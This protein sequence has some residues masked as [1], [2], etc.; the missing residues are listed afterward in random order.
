MQTAISGIQNRREGDLKISRGTLGG[1]L[2][3]HK[4]SKI[5]IK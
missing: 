2:D 1:K 4:E 3:N 5:K